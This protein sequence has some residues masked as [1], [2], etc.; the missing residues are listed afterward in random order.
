[1]SCC[2]YG[3]DEI[4]IMPQG[5]I[6]DMFETSINSSFLAKK[7]KIKN[8]VLTRIVTMTEEPKRPMKTM[9]K[10]E[11]KIGQGLCRTLASAERID[12]RQD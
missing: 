5:I 12:K 8:Q 4:R 2:Y 9:S 6:M 1:M 11:R 10:E 3:I 7:K